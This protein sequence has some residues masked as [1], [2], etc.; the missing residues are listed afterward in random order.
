MWSNTPAMI[1]CMPVGAIGANPAISSTVL[2]SE[3]SCGFPVQVRTVSLELLSAKSGCRSGLTSSS[4]G[5]SS[6]I[7]W[8]AMLVNRD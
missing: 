3:R 4:I 8:L 7:F 1:T 5:L 6:C 2:P